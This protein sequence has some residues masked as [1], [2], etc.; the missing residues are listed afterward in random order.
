ML[1]PLVPMEKISEQEKEMI[2]EESRTFLNE[3]SRKLEKL[4][5]L[6][7]SFESS[8]PRKEEAGWNPNQDFQEAVFQNAPFVEDNLI[9]AEKG[10]WK[11]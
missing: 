5:E 6:E 10:A 1:L 4:K 3:F 11:K 2:K 8:E 7:N 9:I